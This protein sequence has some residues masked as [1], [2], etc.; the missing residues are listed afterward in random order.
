MIETLIFF[1]GAFIVVYPWLYVS[2]L[3]KRI[4]ET[5]KSV[6]F[7]KSER[8][9]LCD[10]L[11]EKDGEIKTLI[12]GGLCEQ[13]AIQMKYKKIY[14]EEKKSREF[15]LFAAKQQRSLQTLGGLSGMFQPRY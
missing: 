12:N 9:K 4:K 7:L 15:A 10:I 11:R 5:N 13:E 8:D 6:D 14:D 3:R 1:G 2:H